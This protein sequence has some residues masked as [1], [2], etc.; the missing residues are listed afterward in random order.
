MTTRRI[1]AIE[2]QLLPGSQCETNYVVIARASHGSSF[3]FEHATRGSV[4]AV[5]VRAIQR[6][7]RRLRG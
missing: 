7:M 6:K 2:N 3:L 4:W 1:R 5:S